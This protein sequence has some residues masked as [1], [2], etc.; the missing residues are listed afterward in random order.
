MRRRRHTHT[1][2]PDLFIIGESNIGEDGIAFCGQQSVGI[3]FHAGTGRDTKEAGLGVY[4][5][6]PAIV[7]DT[8][9]GNVISNRVD[10]VTFGIGRRDQHGQIGL[11]A[12]AGKSTCYI[13][14]FAGFDIFDADQHAR[15]SSLHVWQGKQYA[16]QNIFC[17]KNIPAVT[18]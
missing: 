2:P 1:L 15:P 8:H 12:S 6:K 14:G 9:P 13:L 16:A 7:A 3:G 11:A 4:G 18:G 17:P 5:I 10:F